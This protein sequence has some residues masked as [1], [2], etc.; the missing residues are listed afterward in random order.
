MLK[1][2]LALICLLIP[3][4]A[5]A[6]L[7]VVIVFDGSGSMND[8]FSSDRNIKKID[9]AKS[10][11]TQVIKDLHPDTK[12]GLVVFSGNVNGWAYPLGTLDKTKL[13]A[14]I[15]NIRADGGTPLG[16]YMKE[17]AN[18][19]LKLR[20]KQKYG[21]YKLIVVTDGESSDDAN[22]PLIGQYGILSK[23]LLVEAVGVDMSA[24]HTLATKVAYRSANNPNELVQAVKATLAEVSAKDSVEYDLIASIEPQ[25]ALAALQALSEYDNA[26][27]GTKPKVDEQGKIVIDTNGNVVVANTSNGFPWGWVIG[28]VVIVIVGGIIIIAVMSNTGRF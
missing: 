10:V 20:Q 21:L 25:L 27:I 3:S 22:T 8:R 17:G 9:A 26:P 18:E 2:T 23:G 4:F 14:A 15:N 11:M 24:G 13:T 7:N 12:I 5:Q 6:Q 16:K 19:L 1:Y 28:I